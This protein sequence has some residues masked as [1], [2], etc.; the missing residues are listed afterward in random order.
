MRCNVRF[1]SGMLVRLSLSVLAA[2]AVLIAGNTSTTTQ[3]N[4]GNNTPT[5]TKDIAPI[6]QAN[7]QECH[8]P[9]QIAPM[10]LLTYEQ[11]R[12]WAKAIRQRVAQRTMPPWFLDKTVGI[13]HF[14]NDNSLSDQQIATIEKWV[15]DGSPMGNPKDLPPPKVFEDGGGWRL[16]K[17]FG[18]EPDMVI[19]G[20]L[21]TMKAHNQ[22]QWYR[23][24]TDINLSEPRWVRAVE[25]RPATPAG[26]KI[27]HHILANLY[28]DETNAPEAL[29][30]V[31][32]GPNGANAG[33]GPASAGLLMEWAIGKNY[34]I[35]RE[36]AGKLLMPGAKI[37]WEYHVHAA[38]EQITDHPQLG[39]YFYP[40]GYVP[41]YRTY[42]TAL[43]ATSTTG[44]RLDIP[45]NSIAESQGFHVL[46]APARLE[47]F[48]P[49]MHLRGKAMA[50]E[51]I[52]PDGTTQMLSYVNNFTFNWMT[53]YIY[54]DDAAPVLPKGTII[55]VTAWYDNT[56]AHASNPDP[57]QWVG[58]GDRTVDEMGHAWVN[59]TYISQED[60]DKW[61]AAHKKHPGMNQTAALAQ[62]PSVTGKSQ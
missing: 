53:N 2:G 50:M 12:P 29:V 44:A 24:V 17:V 56:R 58:Y 31:D 7:C 13:Q 37:R 45:P 30:H 25:M 54:A 49:H 33:G 32:L 55:H 3:V 59:V 15:D 23:P 57:D 28:Q 39:V 52:L 41:K 14:A 26:R 1:Q 35:Y 36:N 18:R 48:Q 60:Y 4:R 46:K 10:S 21:Y 51:A 61:A 40:K 43:G 38:G 42:L 5:F 19:N 22:D 34:D 9:G 8:R 20:P 16:T 6:L 27:F 47:N 62:Q 11:V